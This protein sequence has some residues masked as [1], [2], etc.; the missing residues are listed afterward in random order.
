MSGGMGESCAIFNMLC[1]ARGIRGT[2]FMKSARDCAEHK[3]WDRTFTVLGRTTGMISDK[4]RPSIT[5]SAISMSSAYFRR[6]YLFVHRNEFE[7]KTDLKQINCNKRIE[8]ILIE[9]KRLFQKVHYP[10]SVQEIDDAMA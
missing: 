2:I 6:S 9:Q 7:R 4:N 10:Q 1:S 5:D 8:W 3:I